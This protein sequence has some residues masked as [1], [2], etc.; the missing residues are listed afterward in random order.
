MQRVDAV[1]LAIWSVA[2]VG[3][4]VADRRGVALCASVRRLGRLHTPAGR[5]ASTA[6]YTTGAVVLWRHVSK[7]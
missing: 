3:F 6:V 1:W 2:A 4:Y 7:H 5:A